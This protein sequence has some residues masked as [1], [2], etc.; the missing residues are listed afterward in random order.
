MEISYYPGCSLATS[1]SEANESLKEAC[2]AAGLGLHELEDWNCCGTSSAHALDR[3]LGLSL[4]ARNLV[5]APPGRPLMVMC[6]ACYKNLAAAQAELRA[7]P[8]R[9][10]AEERRWGGTIDPDLRIVTFLEMVHFL[11][12]LGEMGTFKPAVR[13]ALA[14]NN[15]LAGLKAAPYHGCASMLP[16]RLRPAGFRPAL[17]SELLSLL[18]AEPLVWALPNRCCG[19]FLTVARPDITTPLVN[20]IMQAALDAGAECL[21]TA[22]AMCQLNI[23]VRCDLPERLPTLHFSEA[24][25]LALGVQ[26][27]PGWFA[28]HLVDPR[29]LLRARRLLA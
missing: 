17:M 24:M 1:A 14:L 15:G 7:D 23:E 25:A 6:P 8:E 10:R 2:R 18:G 9:R 3:G 11:R 4:A 22:C 5:L 20:Q 13:G 28:R 19:T 26:A 27:P 12:K 29:P 16:P 21:V